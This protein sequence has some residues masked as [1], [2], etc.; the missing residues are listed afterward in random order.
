[1]KRFIE[2]EVRTQ[3]TPLPECLDDYVAEGNPVREGDVFVGEF[4]LSALGFEGAELAATG[5]QAYH[6]AVLLKSYIYDYLNRIQSSRRLEHEVG[7]NLELMWLTGRWLLN[8][9]PLPTFV[10]R[11]VWLEV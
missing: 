4:D 7:S 3:I 10:N 11:K 5:H 6:A 2:G 9:K 1:M 8:S